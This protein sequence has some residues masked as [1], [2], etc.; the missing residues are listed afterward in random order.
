MNNSM[1]SF[2]TFSP[3]ALLGLLLATLAGADSLSSLPDPNYSV[4]P[5]G[6]LSGTVRGKIDRIV[7][8]TIGFPSI[9]AHGDT[10]TVLLR[11]KVL[12]NPRFSIQL[13]RNRG[14][15]R[16]RPRISV[17]RATYQKKWG[18]Y[19]IQAR[20]HASVPEDTYDILLTSADRSIDDV[21]P[22]AVKVLKR[23][24]SSFRFVHLADSQQC[25]P[26]GILG[27]ANHNAQEFG[28]VEIM[29]QELEEIRYLDPAFCVLSGD[30]L[31]G[32]SYPVEYELAH[33]V[34]KTSGLP[35]FMVPGNHDGM[36]TTKPYRYLLLRSNTRDGLEYWRRYFGPLY[37]SF[38]FGPYHFV[39]VNSYDGTPSRRDSFYLAGFNHGG[40]IDKKQM[41]WL[42][43]DLQAAH[44]AG[45]QSIIFMHHNPHGAPNHP[46]GPY[47]PNQTF[48]AKKA[49]ED[50]IDYVI[51]YATKGSYK[52]LGQIWNDANSAH[53][54]LDLVQKNGVSHVLLGHTHRDKVRKVGNVEFIET[55]T[56]ASAG[57]YW[58]Y[59]L[60]Q[61]QGSTITP[62]NYNG[63]KQQ[64][65]PGG[66][67]L[68]EERD[69]LGDHNRATI[70]L[71]NGLLN[72]MT[73]KLR[74]YLPWC[75][76]GY[77]V[78]GG[79]IT[80][81]ARSGDK[82]IVTVST[83][84]RAGAS[85]KSPSTQ[86]IEVRTATPVRK[87][88][89]GCA[90]ASIRAIHRDGGPGGGPGSFLGF[91]LTMILLPALYCLHGRQRRFASPLLG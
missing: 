10:L 45:R 85:M 69:N 53:R 86:K 71:K 49:A 40:Q 81:T 60:F 72:P 90:S 52:D 13:R 50:F 70:T 4:L 42:E 33:R 48:H 29:K 5:Q 39:A 77:R 44:A 88:S 43:R 2:R 14:P 68:F 6:A 37:Y 30:L 20:I 16:Y 59:R 11:S 22:C 63:T 89:P 61:V 58:G 64:S 24:P 67:L 79:K 73:G 15:V 91:L 34:W 12:R 23:I 76:A 56:M 18:G 26:R 3:Y 25:D 55:T 47:I 87:K 66:N 62:V 65:I 28:P 1:R 82:A 80:Q 83:Q 54:F 38:D 8:P 41:E 36:A 46:Q 84:V 21:Q 27:P 75:T 35:V 31:T 32:M 74:F 51:H 19:Q 17:L 78:R 9:V 57:Q 7:Y